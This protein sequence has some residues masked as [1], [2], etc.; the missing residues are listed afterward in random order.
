MTSNRSVWL[1]FVMLLPDLA[2]T[3][4]AVEYQRQTSTGN[5]ETQ[6]DRA[7]QIWRAAGDPE[8]SHPDRKPKFHVLVRI[9]LIIVR[10]RKETHGCLS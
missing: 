6:A 10:R 8:A 9:S 7:A 5:G 1:L 3:P 4:D 2:S